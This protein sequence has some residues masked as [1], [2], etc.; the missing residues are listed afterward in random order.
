MDG[1]AS[2]RERECVAKIGREI[3]AAG[4]RKFGEKTRNYGGKIQT[5][6][7]DFNISDL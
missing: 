6:P 2:E 1:E 4:S 5:F 7:F 3:M